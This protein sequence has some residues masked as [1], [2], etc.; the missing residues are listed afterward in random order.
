MLK[1]N[2]IGHSN[3]NNKKIKIKDNH[4]KVLLNRKWRP[5]DVIMCEPANRFLSDNGFQVHFC[6]MGQYHPIVKSFYKKPPQLITYPYNIDIKDVFDFEYNLDEVDLVHSGHV[7][8]VEAFL[9][10]SNINNPADEYKT[11]LLEINNKYISWA[12][13]LLKNN[14]LEDIPLIAV[15]RQSYSKDSPRSIPIHILD[16]IYQLLS[17]DYHI[18]VIGDK[19]CKI[20]INKNIHNFTGCTPD[21]MS[22]AGLLTQCKILLTGDTGLMHL[23]GA[24]GTPMVSILGPTRP[25]DISLFYKNNTILDYGRECSPCFDRG[26]DNNCL[27]SIN[28]DYVYNAVIDR[29]NAPFNESLVLKQEG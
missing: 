11:P 21:I 20:N 12:K 16:E 23:A 10:K 6:T 2:G 24:I 7:S 17:K 27:N 29:I 18:L 28:P 19:P 1:I 4:K 8:K 15:I 26:C 5:G 9:S 25:E 14:H 13:I 3:K 22:V